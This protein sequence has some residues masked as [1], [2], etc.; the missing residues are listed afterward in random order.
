MQRLRVNRRAAALSLAAAATVVVSLLSAPQT[1][2]QATMK[3]IAG[4]GAGG[5]FDASA[6]L[7]SRH[8][9][10]Y[11]PGRP[12]VI[13]QNMPGAGGL[14]AA[15]YLTD[16]VRNDPTTI[17]I[18]SQQ[19]VLS[20][21]LGASPLDFRNFQWVGSLT[22]EQKVCVMSPKSQEILREQCEKFFFGEGAALPPDFVPPKA[23]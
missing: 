9:G 3:I 21:L 20:Q 22:N 10:K 12:L 5:G 14:K 4:Y 11:L 16:V 7:L 2:A 18:F 19:L 13:V 15:S 8:I 23:K 6:R 17:A 1:R